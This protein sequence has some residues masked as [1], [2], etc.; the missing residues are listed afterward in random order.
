VNQSL[1]AG[2]QVEV[3]LGVERHRP[4]V[5]GLGV[6]EELGLAVGGNAVDL[7]VGRSGGVEAVV[8]IEREGVD[9]QGV[10]F[11]QDAAFPLRRD[12]VDARA[13]VARSAARGVEI[14]ARV[15][16]DRP[17]VGRR[18]VQQF[19][20]GGRER[21]A[22]VA[23]QG[24]VFQRGLFKI[25]ELRLAP[26]ARRDRAGAWDKRQR[27]ENADENPSHG[28]GGYLTVK[29]SVWLPLMT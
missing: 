8:A 14:A 25:G 20:E 7:G 9:F 4:G 19:R 13:G 29:L 23:A 18:G 17:Q 11:R 3:A 10:Q 16:D 27:R 21:E 12:H 6:V 24:D 15:L 2:G 5:L 22:A 1:V 28:G 26:R